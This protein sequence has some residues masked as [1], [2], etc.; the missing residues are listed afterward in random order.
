MLPEE[1]RINLAKNLASYLIALIVTVISVFVTVCV[2]AFFVLITYED[3]YKTFSTTTVLLFLILEAVCLYAFEFNWKYFSNL[4]K[5][6][7][8]PESLKQTLV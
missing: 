4:R 5:S 2:I 6:A 8:V 7:L 1:T 3:N